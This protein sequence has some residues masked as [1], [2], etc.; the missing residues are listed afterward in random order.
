MVGHYVRVQDAAAFLGVSPATIR[1]YSLRGWLLPQWVGRGRVAHR[2]FLY[3]DLQRVAHRRPGTS[4]RNPVGSCRAY[5]GR[6]GRP[7]FRLVRALADRGQMVVL[8]DSN[9]LG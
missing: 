7:I 6:P 2:R 4:L 1:W 5:N 3:A 9:R 8:R